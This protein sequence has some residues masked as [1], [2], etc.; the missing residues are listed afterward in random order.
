ML[1]HWPDPPKD[2]LRGDDELEKA[3][4][5]IPGFFKS[6]KV[7]VLRDRADITT[8][9]AMGNFLRNTLSSNSV[10][11]AIKITRL[12]TCLNATSGARSAYVFDPVI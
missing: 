9:D 3:F 1:H 4:E 2:D 10:P 6:D 12:T 5:T 8:H 7:K 11:K